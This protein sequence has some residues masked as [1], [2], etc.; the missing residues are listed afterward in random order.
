MDTDLLKAFYE[1]LK[2]QA[3]ERENANRSRRN[4]RA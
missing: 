3:K 2:Q 4:R 1:V